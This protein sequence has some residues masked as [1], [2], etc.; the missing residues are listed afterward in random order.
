MTSKCFLF[1]VG[2]RG[3][4]QVT[5]DADVNSIFEGMDLSMFDK[6]NSKRWRF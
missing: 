1:H 2:R 4:Y 6:R 3:Q 5:K